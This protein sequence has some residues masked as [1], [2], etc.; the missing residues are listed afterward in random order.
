MTLSLGAGANAEHDL[1]DLSGT[2]FEIADYLVDE[3]MANQPPDI[4]RFLLATS[5][6]DR[7]CAP[8]CEYVLGSAAGQDGSACDVP[9]CM[10]W[11]E[12]HNLFVIPLDSHRQWYRYHHLFQQLLQRRLLSEAGPEQA[13]ELHRRAAAWF[14]GQDLIDEAI[15]HALA[16]NDIGQAAELMV[17]GTCDALNREDSSHLSPLAAPASG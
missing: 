3:V 12:R 16:I 5:I 2:H 11:L 1:A 14:A 10:Q 8:L 7:F 4:V 17:A 15:R 9:A 6:L 13:A